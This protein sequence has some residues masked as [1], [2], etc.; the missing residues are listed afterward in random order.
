MYY[1]GWYASPVGQ[2]TLL[3]DGGALLGLWLEGQAN[4]GCNQLAEAVE[5]EALPLFD[6]VRRWLDDYFLGLCPDPA[7]VPL[8]PMGTA[9]QKRVWQ[10]LLAVPYDSTATY[11]DIARQIGRPR[12][13]QAV[14]SAVGRNPIS[15]IIPC[16]RIVGSQGQLTG[17][18][19]GLERKQWLLRHESSS[20]KS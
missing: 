19:G 16:H 18:A 5:N 4:F 15:I 2:I 17:Y 14:G 7:G 10:A 12:A 9:F 1:I 20:G 13:F 11:G 8:S 3:S 6:Q